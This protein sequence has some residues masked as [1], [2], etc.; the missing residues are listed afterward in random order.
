[1]T[2]MRITGDTLSFEDKVKHV[3]ATIDGTWFQSYEYKKSKAIVFVSKPVPPV[4]KEELFRLNCFYVNL[5]FQE[6]NKKDSELLLHQG[7]KDEVSFWNDEGGLCIYLSV[8]LYALLT[9]DNICNRHDL[10]FVQGVTSYHATNPMVQ[11]MFGNAEMVNFHAWLSYKGTVLD[12]SVG[13][14]AEFIDLGDSG[15]IM[16]EIPKGM[17][18]IGF[19]ENDKTVERYIKRFAEH[20]NMTE[21]QWIIEHKLCSL[22]VFKEMLERI[23]EDK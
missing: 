18:M 17:T 3:Q 21:K 14:E 4:K 12:F 5:L 7:V 22:E 16:G 2:D 13:Q 6:F 19:K 8:V 10:R 9:E 23:Q 11:A 20:R 15:S 1:M